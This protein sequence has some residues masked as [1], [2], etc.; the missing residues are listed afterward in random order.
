LYRG[1]FL[2]AITALACFSRAD[3]VVRNCSTSLHYCRR[4]VAIV[5][6]LVSSA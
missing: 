2:I 1:I 5:N 4:A 3:A 6:T